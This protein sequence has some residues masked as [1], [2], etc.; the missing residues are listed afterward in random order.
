MDFIYWRMICGMQS[1]AVCET[2]AFNN[3]YLP[4]KSRGTIKIDKIMR[5]NY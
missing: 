1:M 4:V 3:Q 2:K 5:V